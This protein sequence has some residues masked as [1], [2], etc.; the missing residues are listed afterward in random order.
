M[1][2]EPRSCPCSYQSGAIECRGDG[3]LWDADSDGY[4]PEDFS[5]PCPAC[6]TREYLANAK[7]YAESTP[8]ASFQAGPYYDHWTGA[9]WWD[10]CLAEAE[11]VNP[12][13]ARKAE[14]ELCPVHA[15]VPADN[16]DG[17][18]AEI[19]SARVEAARNG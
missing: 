4:D 7:E 17:Y 10:R 13:E 3:Y 16:A 2:A 11:R 9:E 15:L 19:I 14:A 1:S 18:S 5:H 8:E 6:N 12:G